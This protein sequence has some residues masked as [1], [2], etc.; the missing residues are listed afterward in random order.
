MAGWF[1]HAPAKAHNKEEV[2]VPP[3]S[4]IPGLN[5]DPSVPT[6]DPVRPLFKETDTKYVR[7]AKQGGRQSE[8]STF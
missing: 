8:N 3:T 7:M 2:L 4:Q 5:Y 6:S 1:Y